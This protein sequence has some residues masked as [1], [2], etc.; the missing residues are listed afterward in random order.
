[1]TELLEE[2]LAD[3][4]SKT[5]EIA[6]PDQR[7][8]TALFTPLEEG[9]CVALLHDISHFKTLERV[10]NEFISTAS[11]DLKNPIGVISGFSDLLSKVG[12]LNETQ[13]GFV[14]HIHSA[15]KNMNELVQNLLQLKFMGW[16][17]RDIGCSLVLK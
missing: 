13:V 14:S 16:N 5:G 10:K 15:A 17:Q 7:V 9:G 4:K 12:P 8:F 1:L 3:G 6:L 2:T 11:H